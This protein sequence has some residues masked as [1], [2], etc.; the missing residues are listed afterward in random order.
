[1]QVGQRSVKEGLYNVFIMDETHS[2]LAC[3][4]GGATKLKN[5]QTNCLTRIFNYKFPY[6]YIDHFDEILN[7]KDKVNK[8]F[9]EL[10]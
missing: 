5:H 9:K 6:E 2:I 1:M 10:K 4:A 8:F 3:G 7:R